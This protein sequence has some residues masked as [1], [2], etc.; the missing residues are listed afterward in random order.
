M[1][2][3]FKAGWGLIILTRMIESSKIK[4][5][6]FSYSRL[7][8]KAKDLSHFNVLFRRSTSG[9]EGGIRLPNLQTFLCSYHKSKPACPKGSAQFRGKFESL[10]YTEWVTKWHQS[11]YRDGF[12]TELFGKDQRLWMARDILLIR[13][14]KKGERKRKVKDENFALKVST[15]SKVN[16]CYRG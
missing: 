16:Q 11:T 12:Q 1:A 13:K 14:K 6:K 3:Y 9:N 5:Q 4:F 7:I 2:L 8:V 15:A 10:T